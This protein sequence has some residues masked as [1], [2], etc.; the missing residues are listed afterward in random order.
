MDPIKIETKEKFYVVGITE[1]TSNALEMSGG[2]KMLLMWSRFFADLIST[3][4]KN[5]VNPNEIVALYSN[6]ES[7]ENGEY[8]YTIGYV[9]DNI[10]DIDD[11]LTIKEVPSQEYVMF[12]TEKGQ[13]PAVL[14]KLWQKIWNASAQGFSGRKRAFNTDIEVYDERAANPIN[15]QVDLYLSV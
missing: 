4:V 1:R 12:T 15:S 7:D 2:G 10:D 6:Y 14:I 3:R 13:M 5:K 8:D 11:N 9:V